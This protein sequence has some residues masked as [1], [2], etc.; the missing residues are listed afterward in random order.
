MLSLLKPKVAAATIPAQQIVPTYKRYRM[1]ALLSVFLGYL[2]YYI[3][4]N[5]FTL[6]TPYLK[7]QLDLS[8]TQIG[9]LSSCM[10]IAY[11]ISKGV[12]SSLADKASPK[13]FMACGLVMCAAVNVG[14]GFSSAFWIFVALVVIN[15][16]FQG[17]GVGPS[18]ITI[19]N[20]FPRRERGRVGAFWNIS[21][22]VG[23]GIVAPIVGTAFALLGTE[24]WQTA[25]YIVPAAVA[26]LFAVVVLILGKARRAAKGCR[27]STKCSRKRKCC[28]IPAKWK[29]PRKT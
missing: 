15:G 8:A 22:N 5:N 1:Q 23:G 20:W 9:M 3:V 2:A 10:L 14:L 21:H 28:S 7:E 26:V 24:H 4:R 19:A 25:S 27:R 6:S 16:L 12:M 17:M 29:K 13:V 11:G 18:F